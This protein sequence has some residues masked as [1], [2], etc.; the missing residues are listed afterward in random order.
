M[1]QNTLP[2]RHCAARIQHYAVSI[3]AHTCKPHE[4]RYLRPL[5]LGLTSRAGR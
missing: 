2:T 1:H 5:T 4:G 3:G